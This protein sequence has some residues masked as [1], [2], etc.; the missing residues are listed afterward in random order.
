[1]ADVFEQAAEREQ[2]DR[3]LSLKQR[4]QEGPKP[5]GKCLHCDAP[6]AGSMRWCDADCR[7][8]WQRRQKR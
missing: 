7:D 6:L 5:A 4:M 1:M 3:E 8:E 2:R